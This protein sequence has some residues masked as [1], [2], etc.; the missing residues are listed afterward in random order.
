METEPQ[1]EAKPASA[2]T[3]A[4]S[5]VQDYL[6]VSQQRHKLFPRAAAVGLAAGGVA[7]V[8]RALLAAGDALRNGLVNWS[9][10]TPAFG[11]IFPVVF[12]AVGAAAAVCLVIA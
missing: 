9:Y 7:V 4:K 2:F 5:E 1:A 12:G 8:F 11:W 3:E 10:S 6:E